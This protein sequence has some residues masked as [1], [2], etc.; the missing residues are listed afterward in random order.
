MTGKI[1]PLP[2]KT[3]TTKKQ[4]QKQMKVYIKWLTKT[5]TEI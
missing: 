3:A 1:R 4:K 5:S 2:K